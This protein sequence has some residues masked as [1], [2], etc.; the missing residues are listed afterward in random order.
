M[1]NHNLIIIYLFFFGS[2]IVFSI[3]INK[4]FLKFS[5]TL[6]IRD[7]KDTIIRWG[8][9]SKP[10]F[11]GISFY[12]IF[13][14]SII[15]YYLII[16]EN[17][18]L[19]NLKLI[20][21][22]IACTLGFLMGL[23]DDAYNTNPLI[24][25]STQIV[26][27][28]ILIFSGT[29]IHIFQSVPLNYAITL[30]WVIGIMNS[31]NMLDNMDAVTSIISISIIVTILLNIF[32]QNDLTNFYLIILIGVL[33]SLIGFVPYNWNPSKIFMGDTG[34]Q[35]LGIFLSIT[36]IIYLWNCKYVN[37]IASKQF[38]IS[39]LVFMLPIIDTTVVVLKRIMRGKSPFVGGKD[40]TTHHLSYI[41]LSDKKVVYVIIA[42]S[43][44]SMFLTIVII[45]YIPNW[46]LLYFI[47]FVLYILVIFAV[48]FYIAN[49]NREKD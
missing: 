18:Y 27:G 26:C 47:C 45:N 44:I 35:F 30:F 39:V 6:G 4:L 32:L 46:N 49:L 14:F 3:L 31:V 17:Y 19:L 28:L 16:K 40:H 15:A 48:L 34:S 29:Y 5:K 36:G 9:Q 1:S 11:G 7:K 23:Y 38:I 8:P 42:I 22:I 21:I 25:L 10:A 43:L 13:L 20:G 12:I 24:K 37:S 41:G 33:G 2:S